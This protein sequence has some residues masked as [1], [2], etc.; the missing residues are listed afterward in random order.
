MVLFH[1]N[2]DY[3]FSTIMNTKIAYTIYKIT[4]MIPVCQG[5]CQVCQKEVCTKWP[6]FILPNGIRCQSSCQIS[7]LFTD[8][9]LQPEGP[10]VFQI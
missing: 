10:F 6:N 3:I 4:L 2:F 9:R 8:L 7:N 1:L 5:V